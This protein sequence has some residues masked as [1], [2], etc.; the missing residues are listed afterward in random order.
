M[1]VRM[2]LDPA[3]LNEA[4]APLI[5]EHDFRGFA[6]RDPTTRPPSHGRCRVTRLAFTPWEHGIQLEA[7]ANRFLYHMVRNLVGAATWV[8]RGLIA[9]EDLPRILAEGKRSAAGPTAPAHGLT[10]EEVVYKA[11]YVPIGEH[12]DGWGRSLS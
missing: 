4:F 7:H 5:G 2:R 3:V 8:T 1:V 11:A 12:V 9:P 10:L 6:A